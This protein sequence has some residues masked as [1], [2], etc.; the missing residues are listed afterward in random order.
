MAGYRRS[1]ARPHSSDNNP[2]KQRDKNLSSG[3]KGTEGEM[4]AEPQRKG[5]VCEQ[6]I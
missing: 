5:D 4:D 2:K 6:H 3:R 1:S